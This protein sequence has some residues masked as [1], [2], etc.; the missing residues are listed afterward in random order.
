MKMT[1][2]ISVN[3]WHQMMKSVTNKRRTR[4]PRYSFTPGYICFT[5]YKE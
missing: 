4:V 3:I 2:G 5:K 1:G